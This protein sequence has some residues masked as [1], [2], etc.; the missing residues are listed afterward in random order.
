MAE[1]VRLLIWD[2][3]ET[4]WRGVLTEGGIEFV[5]RH[6][7]IV[8][9]LARRGIVSSIC[10]KNDPEPVEALLKA[11]GVRDYFVAPSLSWAP[12]GPRIAALIET[13]GLRP[14]SVL[15]VDDNPLN[16]E[17][18]RRFCPDLQ[19]RGVEA[20]A[21]LLDDPL[22]AGKDDRAL[23]R[24]EQYRRL[25]RRQSDARSAGDDLASFLRESRIEVEIET[26]VEP[27]IDRFV[28]LLNRTNQLNFTKRRLPEDPAAA[29]EAARAILAGY[30]RQAAL[31]RVSDRYGDH[32]FCGVY[33]YNSE[34]RKL[35]HFA[36]SCRILGLGVERWLYARLGRPRIEVKGEVLADLDDPAPVD[37]IGQGAPGASHA[38]GGEARIG[39][40]TARGACDLAAIV[41]YFGYHSD[42]AAGEYYLYRDGGMFHI[43]HSVFLHHAALGLT[44]AQKEA[45]ASL[46]YVESDFATR[47]YDPVGEAGAVALLG[48]GADI[49]Q[50][51]LRHRESGLI[52]PPPFALPELWQGRDITEIGAHERPE[53]WGEA[54]RRAH[55]RIRAEWDYI[56]LTRPSDLD[57][58]LRFAVARIAPA[59]RIFLLGFLTR[60]Y[61]HADGRL[62]RAGP[63]WEAHNAVLRALAAEHAHVCV[64]EPNELVRNDEI[65]DRLHFRRGALF[66]IYRDIAARLAGG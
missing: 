1:P 20:L 7:E 5:E 58:L 32:G 47:L 30:N 28:E 25:E 61:V 31:V 13:L 57:A 48:F 12:K 56:G 45:A 59:T 18:A 23:T 19:T 37:W 16:L 33:V 38:G 40:V 63:E 50:P 17:E 64:V 44:P 51:L 53:S 21:G 15:F 65:M 39:R 34:I 52:A 62:R 29:R 27:H 9:E 43:G 4:F 55:D 35:E 24:L 8:I 66:R 41:H 10:S 36:F 26:D 3:D 49:L 11:H 60:D 42:D 2:L 46:G 6:K 14:A 22:L 54:P